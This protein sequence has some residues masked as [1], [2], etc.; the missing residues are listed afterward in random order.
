MSP[1]LTSPTSGRRS[2]RWTCSCRIR[3]RKRAIRFGKWPRRRQCYWR[4]RRPWCCCE[5]G[6]RTCWWAG[7]GIWECWCRYRSCAGGPAEPGRPVHVSAADRHLAGPGVGSRARVCG[8]WP[9][10]PGR[11]PSLRAGDRRPDGWRL[12]ANV[13]LARQRDALA[14]RPA[15]QRRKCRRPGQPGR[16]PG[17]LGPHR[18]RPW[19]TT[20]RRR[21]IARRSGRP[22]L[23]LGRRS[24]R[25]GPA[26]RSGRAVPRGTAVEAQR[27]R[28]PQ[29]AR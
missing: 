14:A 7:Y 29:R 15:L 27:R 5:K 16:N 26:R 20:P 21:R 23:S 9:R 18:P 10:A 8:R 25:S 11:R 3:F 28:N 4:S 22:P 2:G 13:L 12:A 24:G 17:E 1:S 6:T 19:N